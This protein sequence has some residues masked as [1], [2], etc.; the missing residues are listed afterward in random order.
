MWLLQNFAHDI[1]AVLLCHVQKIVVIWYPVME[2]QA[3]QI[4]YQ[5][6]IVSKKY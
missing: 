6:Q 1:T 3:V 4:F 2:F 5:M